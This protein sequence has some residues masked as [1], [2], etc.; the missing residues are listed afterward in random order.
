MIG[1]SPELQATVRGPH[2]S[3]A[4]ADVIRDGAVV[5]KL[6]VHALTVTAD[7]ASPILRRFTAAVADPTGELTP[8]GIRSELAPAGTL[9]APYYGVE[10]PRVVFTSYVDD[11]AAELAEGTLVDLVT[12]PAGD[13]V[14]G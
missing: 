6:A 3:F 1:T 12:T 8:A 13:L 11:T 2:N 4:E 10:I 5:R 9:V 14:L 7:R